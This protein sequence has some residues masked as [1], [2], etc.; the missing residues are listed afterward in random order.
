MAAHP[1]LAE[2]PRARLDG[3]PFNLSWAEVL[4]ES[5]F[6]VDSRR[7]FLLVQPV[8]EFGDLQ[9]AKQSI[10]AVRRIAEDLG[11]E[12]LGE[13]VANNEEVATTH[14]RFSVKRGDTLDFVLDCR[15]G[16]NSDSYNWNQIVTVISLKQAGNGYSVGQSWNARDEFSPPPPSSLTKLELAAQ[17]LLISNE[18]FFVD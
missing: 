16:T 15:G 12:L 10:L 13:W 4:A 8:L 9:P 1:R 3:V 14:K 11:D 6:D 17:A 2:R 18:F 7:R 5:N